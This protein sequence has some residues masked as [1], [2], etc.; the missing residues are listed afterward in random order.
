MTLRVVLWHY[1]WIAPHLILVGIAIAMWHRKL[2]H[3]FPVFFAYVIEEVIQF[4]V[5]YPMAVM[6][7]VSVH[8][9][10]GTRRLGSR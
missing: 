7:S 8:T 6:P 1:L 4:L 9:L 10:R 3:Q 5:I 2:V